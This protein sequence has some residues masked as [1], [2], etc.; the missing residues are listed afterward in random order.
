MDS[1]E[2]SDVI[3]GLDTQTDPAEGS[4]DGIGPRIMPR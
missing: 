2:E 1:Q 4:Y 3:D